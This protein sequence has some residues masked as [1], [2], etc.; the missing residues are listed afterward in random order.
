MRAHGVLCLVLAA[1]STAVHATAAAAT[2]CRRAGVE[3]IVG[4]RTGADPVCER[5]AHGSATP[6]PSA[7]AASSRP[8]PP[9]RWR[10]GDAAT[11][12]RQ[13]LEQ[14]LRQEQATLAAAL[15]APASVPA[16]S[17]SRTRANIAALQKELSRP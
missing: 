15:Q 5:A 1:A 3:W 8:E 11:E 14:E 6:P 17:I 4:G 2:V 13:I 16:A 12:R 10:A 9:A 7:G